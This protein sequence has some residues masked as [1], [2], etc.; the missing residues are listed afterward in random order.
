[1]MT[2]SVITQAANFFGSAKE[3]VT[4]KSR[5]TGKGFEFVMGNSVKSK[6]DLFKKA[7]ISPEKETAV[8]KSSADTNT[9]VTK[10]DDKQIDKVKTNEATNPKKKIKSKETVAAKETANQDANKVQEDGKTTESKDQLTVDPSQTD[11]M[12]AQITTILQSLQEAVMAI[13]HLSP[14][15]FNQLM[16]DQG[17]NTVDLLQPEAL[18]QLALANSGK[19][20]ILAALTDENLADTMKQLIQAMDQIKSEADLP[21]TLEQI[22]TALTQAKKETTLT[23]IENSDNATTKMDVAVTMEQVP[24]ENNKQ[25]KSEPNNQKEVQIEVTKFAEGKES[26]TENKAN[27]QSNAQGNTQTDIQ[28]TTQDNT[29][30][31][32]S[33][34]LKSSDQFQTFVDN[35]VNVSQKTQVNISDQM[36]QITDIKEIANQIIERIKIV[37]KPDQTSMELVLNPENLGKVNLSVQSK[38]GVLTAQFVVQNEMSKEAIESQIQTLK[39]TLNQQGVKVEAIEVTVATYTFEQSNQSKQEGQQADKKSQSGKKISMEDAIN[40]NEIPEE[41]GSIID[42]TELLGNQFDYTA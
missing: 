32:E 31:K 42:V 8:K 9:D 21:F 12:V 22:K 19:T 20:D 29:Q 41:E 17:L 10:R 11:Q 40:W 5:Q 23:A 37:I 33:R 28:A 34:D 13:L 7:D 27:T 4:S 6:Q 25:S 14:E 30:G 3:S 2:Q 15:E 39:E 38:N 36:V 24:V 18:K 26:M 35:L 1:M 16:E